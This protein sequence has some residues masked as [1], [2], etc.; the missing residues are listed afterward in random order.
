MKPRC[1]NKPPI[2][3]GHWYRNGG[4]IGAKP[5]YRWVPFRMSRECGSWKASG[6]D[7]PVPV[8]EGWDCEGCRW[9][10]EGKRNVEC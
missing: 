8:R 3:D 6:I 1:F 2:A 9:E 10:P 5:R 4:A 7:A